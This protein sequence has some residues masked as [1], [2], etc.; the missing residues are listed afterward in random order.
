[1]STRGKLSAEDLKRILRNIV[2]LYAPVL[3]LF[4]D[5]IQ[6][7]QFDWKIMYALAISVSVDALRRWLTDYTK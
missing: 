7:G 6:A 4:L 1:M 3:F 5:Q 2:I